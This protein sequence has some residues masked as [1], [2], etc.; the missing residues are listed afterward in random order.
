VSSRP[1]LQKSTEPVEKLLKNGNYRVQF[2]AR[3]ELIA[4]SERLKE[5]W[6]HSMSGATWPEIIE[7]AFD[8]AIEKS[9]PCAKAQRNHMRLEK[10]QKQPH[11]LEKAR[12]C[13]E[14]EHKQML[15]ANQSKQSEIQK[16]DANSKKRSNQNAGVVCE[17]KVDLDIGC[18]SDCDRNVAQ[19]LDHCLEHN[20][21]SISETDVTSIS[22]ADNTNSGASNTNSIAGNTNSGASNTNSGAD[23]TFDVDP[24]TG[25]IQLR[26]PLPVNETQSEF[27]SQLART[28]A[29][30]DLPVVASN[31]PST[32]TMPLAYKKRSRTIPSMIRHAVWRRDE[33]QCTF[34]YPD[35][36]ICGERMSLE[37]DHMTAFAH[38]GEH[39]PTN[40]R[41]RCRQHN[42]YHY[43]KTFGRSGLR[44]GV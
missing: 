11:R 16:I 3:P 19:S 2:E 33:G 38:G 35:G 1:E 37:I 21:N 14:L 8:L 32:T 31:N 15:K 42:A 5:I 12:H 28:V 17:R 10:T 34:V 4:K 23:N 40:L 13:E 26:L 20:Q 27:K 7:R 22:I 39:V 18:E 25:E 9:D 44:A 6:S 43:I 24:I 29:T 41:L 30:A 36:R